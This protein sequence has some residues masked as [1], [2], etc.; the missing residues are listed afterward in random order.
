MVSDSAFPL[1]ENLLLACIELT[2]VSFDRTGS[3]S[4]CRRRMRT[5]WRMTKKTKPR[6]K[7]KVR[8]PNEINVCNKLKFFFYAV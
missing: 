6:E 4:N 3:P 7:K 1:I 8:G 2:A 5:D